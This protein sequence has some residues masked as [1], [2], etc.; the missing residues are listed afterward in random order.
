MI[1]DHPD[2]EIVGD[3]DEASIHLERIV[4]IYKGV[5]GVAQRRQ[6]EY[7]YKLL[8]GVEV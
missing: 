8:E 6:R 3:D 4:P 2:F 5:S 1:I 7:A